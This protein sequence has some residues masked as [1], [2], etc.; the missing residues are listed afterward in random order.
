MSSVTIDLISERRDGSFCLRLLEEGP[1]PKD[2]ADELQAVEK[3]IFDVVEA[4]IEG[5]LVERFPESSGRPVCIR[6]DCYDLPRT[7]IDLL[8]ARFEAF[9]R[10]SPE[11]AADCQSITFEVSHA[12]LTEAYETAKRTGGPCCDLDPGVP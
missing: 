12:S 9:V 1:W 3:R 5:K 10:S 4:V 2:H 8:V 11:W 7:A 6:L